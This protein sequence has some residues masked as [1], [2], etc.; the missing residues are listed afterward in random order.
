MIKL[1]A[2]GHL[3]KDATVNQVNGKQV[4]NFTVAHT[5][6]Y[7]D[8]QGQ[9][10]SNTTWVNCAWWTESAKVAPYL[11]KGQQVFVEGVPSVDTYTNA[12][13]ETFAQL[14]LR[15]NELQL[16]GSAKDQQP[17]GAREHTIQNGGSEINTGN[18]SH[19]GPANANDI[20]EPIDDLPF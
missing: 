17:Q 14:R 16:V 15:V 8:R 1:Q 9:K 12:S 7:Y 5:T 10:L 11:K 18:Y 3:G 6:T 20:T 13:R 4:I 2:I 19:S